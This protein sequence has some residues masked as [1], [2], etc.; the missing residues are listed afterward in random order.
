M[1]AGHLERKG[2]GFRKKGDGT[3][4]GRSRV[5]YTCIITLILNLTPCV[6]YLT[7]PY[8]IFDPR[9][10]NFDPCVINSTP[11]YKIFDPRCNN[12]DP[13]CNNFDPKVE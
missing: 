8:K 10:N 12:F 2:D 9:C 3:V 1:N 4:T 6:I 11:P 5:L 7:L 13:Q